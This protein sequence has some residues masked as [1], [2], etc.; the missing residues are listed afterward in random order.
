MMMKIDWPTTKCQP[1][2]A[3]KSASFVPQWVLTSCPMVGRKVMMLTA[4]ITG[5]TPAMFT[6]SGR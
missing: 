3:K 2:E 6:R 4:K 1:V 5:M